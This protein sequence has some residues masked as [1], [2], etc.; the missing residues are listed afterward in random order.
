[1]MVP[2]PVCR[3]GNLFMEISVPYYICERCR[4]GEK[5][6]FFNKHS[7]ED[8]H[9]AFYARLRSI[10]ADKKAMADEAEVE[11]MCKGVMDE[12]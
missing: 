9:A 4:F 7:I 1:M 11:A 8:Y 3:H 6:L 10:E 12:N 2:C 5:E